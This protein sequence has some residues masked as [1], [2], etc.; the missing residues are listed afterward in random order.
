MEGLEEG[1]G[2]Q[3]CKILV[4]ITNDQRGWLEEWTKV[5]GI[6]KAQIIRDLIEEARRDTQSVVP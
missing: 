6:S 5:T 2:G 1:N 4:N 3:Y